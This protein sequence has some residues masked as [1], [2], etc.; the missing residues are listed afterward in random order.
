MESKNQKLMLAAICTVLVVSLAFSLGYNIGR[1]QVP[2]LLNSLQQYNGDLD[3]LLLAASLGN[4]NSS[5]SCGI[6]YSSLSSLSSQLNTLSTEAIDLT[7]QP[8]PGVNYTG[9]IVQ[10]AYT[11]V[12][13]WLIAQR[14]ND[15][16]GN[17]IV[18]ELMFYSPKN[19]PNCVTEG[20]EIA[21][22]SSETNASIGVVL[23][24]TVNLQ[25]V[26]SLNRAFNITTFPTLVI[27][28]KYV[29]KGYQT[30][31][32]ILQDICADTNVSS[33]CDSTI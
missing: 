8:T 32:Q 26:S 10:L 19:C 17:K 29:V 27:N 25:V 14:I 18:T 20:N 3:N 28:G 6:L 21:Y 30:L 31:P 22:L 23:D 15:Q 7:S 1:V 2:S 11:R 4:S 9:V 33:F 12:S 24:G 13:Y 16:C 5:A